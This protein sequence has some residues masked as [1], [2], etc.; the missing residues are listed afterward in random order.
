MRK[1]PFF[2][3]GVG[4]SGTTLIR[5]MMHSHPNIA[6]PYETHFITQYVRKEKD[7]GDLNS[8]S[9]IK[10]LAQDVLDEEMLKMWDHQFDIDQLLLN[11]QDRSLSGL[12]D[13]IYSDYAL[14]KGKKR[15]G[16]KSDYLDRMHEINQVFPDAKFIHIIRDGRDVAKSVIKMSW[17]PNDVIEAAGWWHEHIRLGR[18]MGA[19]LGENRYM[20]VKY[21][22]L[23]LDPESE[24]RALCKFID[25]EYSP[26]ML[27]YHENSANS[28]PAE[29]KH[30]HYNANVA[31]SSERT[32]AWKREMS[33]V[34]VAIFNE[35][36]L[37]TLIDMGYDSQIPKV[38]K[39]RKLAHKM[40]LM[41]KRQF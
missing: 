15:W 1:P 40:L 39:I 22:N 7:Y 10:R 33:P 3:V 11:L 19:I 17:G 25:E 28:I 16:D 38:S 31:P 4:R 29:R 37:P 21:E 35:Q 27:N 9:N 34:E 23:V 12:L 18:C 32:Y 14:S 36:A 13:A 30:Q 24:L 41:V 2:I 26:E 5:L 6:I 8:D 20:E